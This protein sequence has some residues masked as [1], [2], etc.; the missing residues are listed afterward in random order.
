M[1]ALRWSEEADADVD[2]LANYLSGFDVSAAIRI[3]D[4]IHGQASRLLE[5]PY[6]GRTGRVEGTRELPVLR[7]PYVI[8][9]AVGDDVAIL[10]VL[11]G[12][13]RWP[14]STEN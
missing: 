14:L 6:S 1:I 11:H 8:V 10:R 9:Y 5:F 7:T 12:A 13:Q 3:V 2:N 4:E